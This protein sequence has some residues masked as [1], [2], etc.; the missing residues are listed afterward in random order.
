MGGW[1]AAQ[2]GSAGGPQGALASDACGGADAGRQRR[3][4]MAAGRQAPAAAAA[5]EQGCRRVVLNM[6]HAA[7]R[8]WGAAP[9]CSPS[10]LQPEGMCKRPGRRAS[11]GA[12]SSQAPCMLAAA[13]G[14]EVRAGP[15]G[16][17]AAKEAKQQ[18]TRQLEA[19]P[20][21]ASSQRLPLA[22]RQAARAPT[23]PTLAAGQAAA[24]W[25]AGA[26][27]RSSLQVAWTCCRAAT[28]PLASPR[29]RWSGWQVGARQQAADGLA[30]PWA[31]S[32]QAIHDAQVPCAAGGAWKGGGVWRVWRPARAMIGAGKPRVMEAMLRAAE[33][34]AKLGMP[35]QDEQAASAQQAAGHEARCL[36]IP[37]RLSVGSRARATPR[38]FEA[39]PQAARTRARGSKP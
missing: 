3:P 28:C 38:P 35:R 24:A 25:Q 20:H 4:G 37:S 8:T 7:R 14:A 21:L 30:G 36:A 19:P 5:Q 29:S 1:G 12:P 23:A 27:P 16:R 22:Q 26:P 13:R 15:A 10:C 17:Q 33:E 11:S 39:V 18:A 34:R 6:A 2:V 32:H 9:A 31:A